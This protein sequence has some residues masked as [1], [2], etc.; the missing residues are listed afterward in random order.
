MSIS[1]ASNEYASVN[2]LHL[3]QNCLTKE[4]RALVKKSLYNSKKTIKEINWCNLL[5]NMFLHK[6]LTHL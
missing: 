3:N 1:T 4:I 6:M 5:N 2:L